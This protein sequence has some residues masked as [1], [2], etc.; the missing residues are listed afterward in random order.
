M[1][2][3]KLPYGTDFLEVDIPDER[4]NGVLISELHHYKPKLSQV[5]LVRQALE[6]PIGTPKLREIAKGKN[7]VCIISS[8][9]TRPVPSKIIMPLML[10]EISFY[11]FLQNL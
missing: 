9:H 5:E 6:N 1:A 2:V 7:K 10:E 3:V 4:L 8:D 11:S